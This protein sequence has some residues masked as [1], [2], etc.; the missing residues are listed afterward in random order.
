MRADDSSSST[1]KLNIIHLAFHD[2]SMLSRLVFRQL[3]VTN[4]ELASV[5]TCEGG[6]EGEGRVFG[7]ERELGE[8]ALRW[9]SS[10]AALN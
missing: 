1:T 7:R 4:C 2:G 8:L 9:P 6:R 3:K 10:N 5:C